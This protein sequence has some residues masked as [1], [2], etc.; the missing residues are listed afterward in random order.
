MAAASQPSARSQGAGTRGAVDDA[1]MGI[2]LGKTLTVYCTI[3]A[4]RSQPLDYATVASGVS[5]GS[6]E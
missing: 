2:L 3:G 6:R 4:S 1:G 5:I